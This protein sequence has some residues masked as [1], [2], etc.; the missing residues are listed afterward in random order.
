MEAP[1][2]PLIETLKAYLA[3]KELLLVLDNFEQVLGASGAVAALVKV[4]PGVKV[5]VTSRVKLNVYG[6]HEY[7]VPPLS[8]PD[9]KHLPPL[10]R[11]SEY[12]AVRLFIERARAARADFELSQDNA[13]AVA[14]ICV[15]LDGLPL[16]IELAAARI[17]M[18][19]TEALLSR[20]SQRLKLLTGG[21][22]IYPHASRHYATP[23]SGVSTCSRRRSNNCFGGWHP[24]A[25]VEPWR[26]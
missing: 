5:V 16:A 3:E 2:K 22:A 6:E 7:G 1:G 26:H 18:L 17:K 8:L 4:A 14:E 25:A 13:T 11:L 24:S 15:R 12:E 23:S 19:P 21:P 20:L 10:E 9:I